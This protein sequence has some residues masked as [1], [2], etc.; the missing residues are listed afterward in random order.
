MAQSETTKFNAESHLLLEQPLLRLPYELS[1]KNF[2]SAQRA[3]EREKEFVLSSLKQTANASLSSSKTTSSSKNATTSTTSN[4]ATP[5]AN[6][7]ATQSLE[8]LD[9]MITRMQNL[10]RKLTTLHDQEIALQKQ[11]RRRIQHLQDLYEI[12]SLADV[13]YEEWSKVRLNRLLVDYLLRRGYME[14]AQNLAKQKGIEDL[15]DL[16]VF[17]DCRLIERSLREGR[18]TVEA[19]AWCADHKA[20]MKKTSSN[21]EFELRLQQYIELRREGKV[22]E[23]RTHAQKH[24]A[25]HTDTHLE[26]IYHTAGLLIFPPDTQIEPYKSMY[27]P[28]RWDHLATLFIQIHHS[29]F[30]LPPYP[31]LHSALS[32]GLSALK[33]PACHSKLASSSSNA[34]STTTSICPICSTELNE[35][36]RSLPYAHH[37]KSYVENDPVVLPNGRI[38]GRERLLAMSKKVGL[39]VGRV[40]DPTTGE[41]FEMGKV[42]KVYI[43]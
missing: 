23:A 2:K 10:K 1:R 41:D 35:L 24:I 9:T 26:D 36:A 16:Q 18:S 30:S 13:K 15:V 22:L 4:D 40:R 6:P 25:S 31:L 42:R 12:P 39:E 34:R 43:S 38:Y 19:L 5:P 8:A 3:F 20:L 17:E 29:L 11:S 37:T 28:T 21:L 14:S 27:S 7:A 33:T 32:A